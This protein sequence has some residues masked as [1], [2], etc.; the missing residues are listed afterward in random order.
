MYYNGSF[1]NTF[2]SLFFVAFVQMHHPHGSM[3]GLTQRS[4][5]CHGLPTQHLQQQPPS[6]LMY[7]CGQSY[8]L[9]EP[10]QAPGQTSKPTIQS[11]AGIQG[12]DG[13]AAG[14]SGPAPNAASALPPPF[15]PKDPNRMLGVSP[16]DIDKYSRV[17]FPVCFVCFNLMYW[18]I[19]MHISDVKILGLVPLK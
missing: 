5:S 10:Q 18:V 4:G 15:G 12:K 7:G 19:Y 14:S 16:S 17:V 3:A 9:V 8:R 2:F 13:P 6:K 1:G 11:V